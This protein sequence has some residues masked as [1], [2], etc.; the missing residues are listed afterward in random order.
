MTIISTKQHTNG[1]GQTVT[2]TLVSHNGKHFMVSENPR[3]TLV[4]VSDRK[5]KVSY[6]E[7]V[8]SGFNTAD[9]LNQIENGQIMS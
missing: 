2:Q 9:C 5:G 8:G 4:F 1:L 3:E 6:A 7:E